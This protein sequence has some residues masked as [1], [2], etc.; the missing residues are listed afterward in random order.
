MLNEAG[1]RLWKAMSSGLGAMHLTLLVE[2][3]RIADRL[4]KL[5][6]VLRGDAHEWLE[7]VAAD[8]SGRIAV[9]IVDKALGEARQQAATLKSIV[10]ELRQVAGQAR[11]TTAPRAKQG[12][13]GGTVA[14]ITARIAE[15]GG[16]AAG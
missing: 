2:A 8:P 12:G 9:V 6:A 4:D 3:C 10:A 15:R 1:S 16:S 11:K 13:A 14:D 7:L 5:D